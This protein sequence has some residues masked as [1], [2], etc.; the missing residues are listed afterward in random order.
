MSRGCFWLKV[1]GKGVWS[2]RQK[3]PCNQG[4]IVSICKPLK[5]LCL[6]FIAEGLDIS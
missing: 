1:F 3:Y 5:N 6:R 2:I 4:Y